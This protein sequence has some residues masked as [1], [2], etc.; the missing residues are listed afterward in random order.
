MN[1]ENQEVSKRGPYAKEAYCCFIGCNKLAT[2]HIYTPPWTY[3]DYTHSCNDH[4][5]DLKATARDVVEEL[6]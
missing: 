1:I 4:I 5:E 6:A 3:D 2:K